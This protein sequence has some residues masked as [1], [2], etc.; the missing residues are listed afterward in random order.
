MSIALLLVMP[1][2]LP[3][4]ALWLLVFVPVA[5]RSPVAVAAF[6]FTL[7]VPLAYLVYPGWIGGG[8][9]YLPWT[10]R[11]IEYGLPALWAVREAR[12]TWSSSASRLP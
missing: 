6:V 9:W 4:Y 5:E 12:L 3:W 1:N 7:T 11:A 8:A 2:V 10:I